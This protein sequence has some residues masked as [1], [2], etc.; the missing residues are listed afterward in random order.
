[1]SLIV[2]NFSGPIATYQL[3][4]IAI[5]ASPY[6]AL[7]RPHHVAHI[8]PAADRRYP[9]RCLVMHA[10]MSISLSCPHATSELATVA[11]RRLRR[12]CVLTAWR[13]R[14]D[15]QA[16]AWRLRADREATA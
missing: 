12:D 5:G 4:P 15:H 1:M 14:R 3:Y 16:A 9:R 11:A 10:L 6:S 2:G 7:P 13:S 8:A